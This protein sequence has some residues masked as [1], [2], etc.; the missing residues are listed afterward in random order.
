[1]ESLKTAF[2]QLWK[3]LSEK[4]PQHIVSSFKNI[5]FRDILDIILMTLL[6][7]AIFC[8]T[9]TR[10]AGRLLLGLYLVALFGA[11]VY[12][13]RLPTLAF[14]VESIVGVALAF[15][16]VVI[17]QPELRDALESLGNGRL[18][19]PLSDM[20]PRRKYPLAKKMTDEV[21]DA[22][23]QMSESH[24]GALIVF[25]GLTKLGDYTRSGKVVNADVTSHLLRNIF[26]E[27]AP[28]HDG[29]VVIRDMKIYAASCVL[30][31]SRGE[32]DF[33]GMGTRHRA[34][35]GVTEVSDALVI[36]V[37]EQT[38]IISV[39]QNGK[40]VRGISRQMLQ[41]ILMTYVAGRTYL[42]YK[43]AHMQ[44][45]Y[46]NMLERVAAVRTGKMVTEGEDGDEDP[47]LVEILPE[48]E[49]DA[50]GGEES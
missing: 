11:I 22:V 21:V 44:E 37:S 33:G 4:A 49:K 15:S 50:E 41:D 32:L 20:L 34:A 12:V 26:F 9:R 45:S 47:S 3:F 46:R 29:A 36:V 24:T 31:S 38:G 27:N 14:V 30:P 42:N 39:A 19:N 17:F 2:E 10:R 25:E 13:L 43:R 1:M 7:Y 18:L 8:F 23:F 40:L 16:I 48:T 35:V 5:T 28:L 6:L